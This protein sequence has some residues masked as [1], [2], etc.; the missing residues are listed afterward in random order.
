ME[1]NTI[2]LDVEEY[3][4]IIFTLTEKLNNYKFDL[5]VGVKLKSKHSIKSIP[6][7][8]YDIKKIKLKIS[9]LQKAIIK[10]K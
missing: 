7:S 10:L 4:Y 5:K 8:D 3:E 6:L 9:A 2:T 1:K